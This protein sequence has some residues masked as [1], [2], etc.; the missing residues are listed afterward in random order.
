MKS[1]DGQI[2]LVTFRLAERRRLVAQIER[3]IAEF[4]RCSSELEQDLNLEHSRTKINDPQHFAY[5]PLAKSLMERRE[6]T[7][8]SIHE[9]KGQ[10][11]P[12]KVEIGKAVDD[13][14]KLELLDGRERA[15]EHANR[16]T[17]P[18][19]LGLIG[20]LPVE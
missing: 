13:L 1:L 5:S 6:K 17:V 4:E 12:A 10:L 2:R 9:L 8:L 15:Q 20:A 11:E 7:R 14:I 16:S 3:M 19:T 18:N